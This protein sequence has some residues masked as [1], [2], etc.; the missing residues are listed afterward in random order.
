MLPSTSTLPPVGRGLTSRNATFCTRGGHAGLSV[1]V[2]NPACKFFLEDFRRRPG[3]FARCRGS[4][5]PA[6]AAI[7]D[8][9]TRVLIA[10]LRKRL[11]FCM[12]TRPKWF[13]HCDEKPTLDT[14]LRRASYG[15]SEQ[16]TNLKVLANRTDLNLNLSFV[17][18]TPSS[19]LC[20]T[21]ARGDNGQRVAKIARQ[22]CRRIESLPACAW[23]FSPA[24]CGSRLACV[25]EGTSTKI[26]TRP[27]ASPNVHE[28]VITH[29]YIF[30]DALTNSS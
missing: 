29:Y 19:T 24:A 9:S 25:E 28:P 23:D 22:P 8:A 15:R 18:D 14:K 20:R 1:V 16:M 6:E 30:Q 2:R 21:L 26:R 13:A 27:I 17:Y 12:H 7:R 4:L 11:M 3:S 5:P 10:M